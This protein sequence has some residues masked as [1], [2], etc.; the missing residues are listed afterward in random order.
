M[1]T[2]DTDKLSARQVQQER[3]AGRPS[4]SPVAYGGRAVIRAGLTRYQVRETLIK[5]WLTPH[6]STRGT[7][8]RQ[9]L[10]NALPRLSVSICGSKP[11]S[12]LS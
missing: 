7:R 9:W 2:N 3:H 4:G 10:P 11:L 6:A 5:Y 1:D 8:A 12:R